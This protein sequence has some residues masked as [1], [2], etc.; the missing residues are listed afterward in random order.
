MLVLIVV[1]W[2]MIPTV[3]RVIRPPNP[4]KKWWLRSPI[5]GN[6]DNGARVVKPDGVVYSGY[7]FVGYDSY[8]R[9]SPDTY[10]GNVWN[11]MSDGDVSYDFNGVSNSYGRKDRRAR[12]VMN[13][14]GFVRK[15][16]M[17]LEMNFI[18][19]TE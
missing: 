18:F 17:Y 10:F 13:M 5:T 14:H 6:I 7:Y 3:S 8:G 16:E 19:P 4:Y 12:V 1:L 15:M 11:V 2:C 9:R